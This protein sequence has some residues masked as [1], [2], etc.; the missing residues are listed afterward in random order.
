MKGIVYYTRNRVNFKLGHK[1]RKQLLKANLPIISVSS[2][3]INFG[4][5]FVLNLGGGW[6]EYFEKIL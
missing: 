5:N 4:K 6:I 1:C 3:P 2:R